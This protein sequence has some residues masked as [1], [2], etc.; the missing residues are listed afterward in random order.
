MT[1]I[2]AYCRHILPQIADNRWDRCRIWPYAAGIRSGG[3][4]RFRPRT[5]IRSRG[6]ARSRIAAD[7]LGPGAALVTV[8]ARISGRSGGQLRSRTRSAF[9]PRSGRWCGSPRSGSAIVHAGS[10]PASGRSAG[11]RHPFG[12]VRRSSAGSPAG[13]GCRAFAILAGRVRP[14][15]RSMSTP[16]SRS[17]CVQRRAGFDSRSSAR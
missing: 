8:G 14:T 10:G 15:Q 5:R 7:R 3:R 9:R 16:A 4:E 12:Y 6:R 2:K 1:S 13:R 11:G 17:L